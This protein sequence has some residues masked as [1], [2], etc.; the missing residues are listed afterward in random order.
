MAQKTQAWAIIGQCGIENWS[1]EYVWHP[2]SRRRTKLTLS[3]FQ[4]HGRHSLAPWKLITTDH[5]KILNLPKGQYIYLMTCQ[6]CSAAR[7]KE[8]K[9]N[10]KNKSPA[11]SSKYIQCLEIAT[12]RGG[13][14]IKEKVIS[15]SITRFYRV[16]CSWACCGE[17]GARWMLFWV[18][19][20]I[21]TLNRAL[22][23]GCIPST[24]GGCATVL[25]RDLRP[26]DFFWKLNRS[27]LLEHQP[28]MRICKQA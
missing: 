27:F 17:R 9:K 15:P 6:T 26:A 21:E 13:K 8:R 5:P 20:G 22:W 28:F 24:G 4:V 25:Y 7:Q 11:H 12:K 2:R 23:P 10:S 1:G 19:R 3:D 16:R 18:L 14:K